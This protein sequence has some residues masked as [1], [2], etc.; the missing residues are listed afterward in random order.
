VFLDA[1]GR[2]HDGLFVVHQSIEM[3]AL[4]D[5]V[6]F[7]SLLLVDEFQQLCETMTETGQAQAQTKGT[8]MNAM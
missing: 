8:E 1:Q 3:V 2:F 6:L 4:L 7:P 5:N